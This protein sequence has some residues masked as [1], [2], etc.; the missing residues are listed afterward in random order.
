LSEWNSKEREKGSH[1]GSLKFADNSRSER[2]GKLNI[3]TR[4]SEDTTPPPQNV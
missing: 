4:P 2:G 1:H 3:S